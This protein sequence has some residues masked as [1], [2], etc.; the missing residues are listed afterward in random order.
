MNSVVVLL[1][2]TNTI[3]ACQIYETLSTILANFSIDSLVTTRH[4]CVVTGRCCSQ[5]DLSNS[6]LKDSPHDICISFNNI[7]GFLSPIST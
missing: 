1:V 3:L 4:D 7:D 2:T 6:K 5:S